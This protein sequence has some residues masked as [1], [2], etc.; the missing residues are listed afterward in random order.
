MLKYSLMTKTKASFRSFLAI[1]LLFCASILFAA[2]EGKIVKAVDVRG[3]KTVSSLTILAKVKTQ[4]GQP[5]SSTALNEDLKRLYGL[6]Y[7]TDVRIEQEDMDGGIKVV[8]LV[9]E[10]SVLAEI[11]IEGNQ[12][13]GK[14]AIKKEMQS[15]TGDFIDQKRI[16]DDIDAIKKL[17]EKKGF[18]EA[19]VESSFDVNPDTNQATLKILINEGQ[20]LRIREIHVIGNTSIKAG[21]ITK[22]MKTKSMSWW[23][24]FHSGY[25]KQEELDEDI[26]RIKALYDEAGFS[27]VDV[28]T[29]TVPLKED[30]ALNIKINEGKKY[31]VGNVEFK[32][33][34]IVKSDEILKSIKMLQGK[35]FSRRGLRMDVSNI[36]DL[37][38][39]RGYLSA[40]IKSE[41]LYNDK[42][43]KVD[44]TYSIVE[45]QLTYVDKVRVQG[46]TKTKD[47]V[48][49]RELR[50][51]PGES[52][53]GAKL[54]R[55]KE[56]LYN[57]GFFEDVRFDTEDGSQPNSKDLV[58]SVKEGKTG[59]FSFGGGYSSIDSIIGFVQVRQKNFDWQNTK[60]F[61]GAGQDFGLRVEAGSVRKNAELSFTEP[62]VFG[63]PYAFGFDIFRKEYNSSANSGYFFD[64]TRTGFDL[65]LGKEFTELDKGL[66]MYKLEQ[67]KISSI[68][69][70][71]SADL[72]AELGTHTTSSIALTL[73]H[74]ERDNIYNPTKGFLL[75]GTGEVAG[76]GGDRDFTKLYGQAST[77]FKHFENDVLELKLRAGVADSYGHTN[78]VPIYERYFAGGANTIRGYRER[79]IGPRDSGNGDPIGGDA[80]WIANLE[81]TFPIY[82]DLIKGALFFD[83]GNVEEKI[84][85]FGSGGVFSGTGAGVR[86]KTPIGPVKLDMGYPLDDV[87]GEGKKVRFYFSVSQGF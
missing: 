86:I 47:I 4:I 63:Y 82:P 23:G 56:R 26:E 28:T 20:K 61:T 38:F 71:S 55:S 75:T 24:W 85:D 46:N 29:E 39:D 25:L 41:S 36:Q 83:T 81:E 21:D 33:N 30:I 60:T 70:N 16:R 43:D 74:D 72:A 48:I 78:K 87:P 57:L 9:T 54:K 1:F 51:Y 34:S 14:D 35:P 32:G 6:G 80:Y 45:N 44:I 73:T 42:T 10:K 62:W 37:Y 79:R 5:V 76:L 19:Q 13:I 27:D 53:S 11:K 49:R 59:E 66:L 65:R 31:I 7:F 64:E 12:K 15:V 40:Q 77:Y 84:G 69:E 58:V 22:I 52:F 68:P 3:N 18:S 8:F 67:V 50:A 17:Y 2:D